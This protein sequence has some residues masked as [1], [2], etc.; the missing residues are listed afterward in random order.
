MQQTYR[1]LRSL[2]LANRLIETFIALTFLTFCAMA[3]LMGIT[4]GWPFFANAGLLAIALAGLVPMNRREE[5]IL[6]NQWLAERLGLD[7]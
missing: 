7:R 2:R 1:R 3:Y 6:R 5:R 4:D